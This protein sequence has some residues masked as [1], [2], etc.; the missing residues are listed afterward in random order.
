MA[1]QQPYSLVYA[2]VVR[3]H[4][5]AIDRGLHSLIR[6]KIEAQLP[7]EPDVETRNRRPVA[8]PTALAAEW[9]LG[10]GPE[11]CLRVLYD[12]DRP[13][14]TVRIL[15][16]AATEPGRLLIDAQEMEL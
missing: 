13:S 7:F 6:L 9:E 12:I 14:R 16:I 10:F 1:R 8:Q 2:P 15:A 5:Q 11:N 3:Q 4:L